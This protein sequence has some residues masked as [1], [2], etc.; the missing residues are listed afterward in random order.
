MIAILFHAVE[1]CYRGFAFTVPKG[2]AIYIDRIVGE[3]AYFHWEEHIATCLTNYL[4]LVTA[5]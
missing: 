4:D 5:V 3:V 2:S 1:G